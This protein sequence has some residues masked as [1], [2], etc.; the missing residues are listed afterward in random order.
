[1]RTRTTVAALAAAAL[2]AAGCGEKNKKLAVVPTEGRVLYKGKPAVGA[3]VVLVPVADDSP[4]GVKPRG[5]VGKDGAFRLTTYDAA[6]GAPPG[7]YRVSLRW[8]RPRASAAD[9]DEG[10][11]PG[12]PGG[13]QPDVF[14]ERYSDPKKSGL[15]VRVEPGKP[16]DPILLK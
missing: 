16:I 7:E 12:P 11:P 8:P 5:V 14:G 15:T 6:D 2:A 4:T 13:V 3:R 9:A 1:M 10:G